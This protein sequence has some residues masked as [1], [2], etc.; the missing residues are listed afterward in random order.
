MRV[1]GNQT[2]E[3][4]SECFVSPKETLSRENGSWIKCM[5]RVS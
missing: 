3:M 2:S 1:N 5:E 4:A